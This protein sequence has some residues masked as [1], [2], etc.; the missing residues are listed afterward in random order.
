M[1]TDEPR[2]DNAGAGGLCGWF[3][4]MAASGPAERTLARMGAALGAEAGAHA[5]I[6]A[7]PRAALQVVPTGPGSGLA[8]EGGV[9][10]G[11]DGTPRWSRPDLAA[12]AGARGHAT[13]LLA[14]YRA[15]GRALLD[16]LHGHFAAV[17]LDPE[18]G[19]ALFA[20]DRMG[21]HPLCVARQSAG[22][23][24]FGTTTLAVAAHPGV[25]AT[26][27]MQ[28]L[29]DYLFFYR[30]PAP[31]TIYEEQ[32]KL[33]PAQVLTV[34]DGVIDTAFYWRMPYG[35]TS[36]EA[37][38]D[39]EAALF[40]SLRSAMGNATRDQDPARVGTFLSGGL[41]SSA[42]LGLWSE[43]ADGPAQ[44]FTI[45]FDSA[46]YDETEYAI[47]AAQHFGAKH[48]IYTVTPE[49][50]A[51]L[52]PRLAVVYDEPF[53]N[54]SA[55]PA[56]YCARLARE[57]GVEVMLAGDGGDEVF[58]GNAVYARMKAFDA[59]HHLPRGLRRG[60]IE[61]LVMGC[62][63]GDRVPPLRKMRSYISQA[64]TPMPERMFLD[65]LGLFENARRIMDED[66]LAT[67]DPRH[68]QDVLRDVYG[69]CAGDSLIQRMMS[70]DQQII[71]ADNDLRKVGRMCA[72]A[73]IGVRYP[74]LD[75]DVV[76]MSATIPPARQ[77][78]GLKLRDFFRRAMG[79]FLPAT[80]L[81][82]RKHG[83]G[84]PYGPWIAGSAPL[85]ELVHDNV[86][87]FARRGYV[88][89]AFVE[90]AL[91]G[92]GRGETALA[93]TLWDMMI[94]ELWL[95]HHVDNRGSAVRAETG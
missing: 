55:V 82:K 72:L 43:R 18:R 92:P 91:D 71:L 60:L 15:H 88:R 8:T 9:T 64:N 23:I 87:A 7:T 26:L 3:G 49:D 80:V 16:H 33:L 11:I 66:V 89:R 62:P 48:H 42:V 52:A 12:L 57:H 81:S 10:A 68:P 1:L 41:D 86:A 35:A 47:A 54:S 37:R 14:A 53:G 63:G 73:G 56:Y 70:L 69:R 61:P 2:D 50:V 28:A 20:I 31:L 6:L 38:G 79:G 67:I 59:Y 27:S 85:R 46:G 22:G 24:V 5:P 45:G 65:A 83:F 77:I 21:V 13:A 84:L 90:A 4:A 17:I 36:R 29:Y 40:A 75:D 93:S 32:E 39:L 78:R 58:A 19:F 34:A 51:A 95:Q 76:E 44:A 25:S 74:L 30:V 94:L